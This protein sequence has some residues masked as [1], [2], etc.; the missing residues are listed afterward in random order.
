M[1]IITT[2]RAQGLARTARKNLLR[3]RRRVSRGLYNLKRRR[4]QAYDGISPE[5]MVWIFGSAR[6]GSIWL[7]SMMADLE[8]HAWWHEPMVGYLFGHLYY[9]RARARRRDENF[10]LG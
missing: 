8:D 1:Q 7:G 3:T 5:R 4:R 10:I 9:E 6:T 2:S